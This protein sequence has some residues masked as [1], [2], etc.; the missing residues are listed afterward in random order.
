MPIKK[1]QQCYS[2]AS[3][4]VS[5]IS[6]MQG[7]LTGRPLQSQMASCMTT[8]MTTKLSHDQV[9]FKSLWYDTEL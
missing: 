6:T 1:R 8:L 3:S 4:N 7:P 5:T 2:R 9:S